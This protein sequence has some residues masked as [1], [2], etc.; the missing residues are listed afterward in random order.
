M[1]A[2]ASMTRTFPSRHLGTRME[3]GHLW[4]RLYSVVDVNVETHG[5]RLSVV[6][7]FSLRAEVSRRMQCVSTK[8]LKFL[9]WHSQKQTSTKH[10]IRNK[11]QNLLPPIPLQRGRMS[12]AG[13]GAGGGIKYFAKKCKEI[14]NKV[15]NIKYK[16][17]L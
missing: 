14:T 8:M 9:S 7:T 15:L 1:E 16:E 4:Q 6:S 3:S 17:L 12:P 13:G 10:E 2:G 5:M 11:F